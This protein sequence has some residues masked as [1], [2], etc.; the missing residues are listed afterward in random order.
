MPHPSS[1]QPGNGVGFEQT[2]ILTNLDALLVFLG[3]ICA[4]TAPGVWVASTDMLLRARELPGNVYFD[5]S[6]LYMSHSL[7]RHLMLSSLRSRFW[8]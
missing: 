7:Q 1:T 2:E 6:A 5:G 8:C 3:R 4:S